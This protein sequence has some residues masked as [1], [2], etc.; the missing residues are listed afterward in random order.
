[1]SKQF[2]AFAIALL[3]VDGK[4]SLDDHIRK[5][6]P[7]MQDFGNTVTIRHL[8]H[9][10]SGMRCTFPELLA[11]AEFRDTDATTYWRSS[12]NRAAGSPLPHSARSAYS[13]RW[14]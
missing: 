6:Q 7:Q 11:L 8:I 2:T 1:M 5:H 3:E 13:T 4:P 9:H 10:S 12:V 14:G